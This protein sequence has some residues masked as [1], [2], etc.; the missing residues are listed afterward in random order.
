MR[1]LCASLRDLVRFGPLWV[2]LV[3]AATACGQ[4]G[5]LYLR[6]KPPPGVKPAKPP[7]PKPVPYPDGEPVE[8]N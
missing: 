6:D 8:K 4:K 2:A 5:P 3:L 7:T 1:I